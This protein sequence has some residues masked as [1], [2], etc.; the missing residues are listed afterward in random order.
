MLTAWMVYNNNILVWR[1]KIYFNFL[2]LFFIIDLLNARTTTEF[3]V[4]Q[5]SETKM[6]KFYS[7]FCF[8]EVII[9]Y[10]LTERKRPIFSKKKKL[11]QHPNNISSRR[12]SLFYFRLTKKNRIQIN[13]YCTVRYEKMK[14]FS[15]FIRLLL[16]FYFNFFSFFHETN[17]KKTT[18][19]HS[20][21]QI[22][23]WTTAKF[24]PLNTIFVKK[25]PLFNIK[26]Y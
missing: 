10:L 23:S 19:I 5:K 7:F 13:A 16:L 11:F 3:T 17:K 22:A 26:K 18:I 25:N 4:I 1:V 14:L 20:I 21:R 8:S 2:F 12:A 15:I 9:F 6:Y 24:K